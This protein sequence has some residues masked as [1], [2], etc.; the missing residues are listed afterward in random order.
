M[1][2][3][4]WS[5]GQEGRDTAIMQHTLEQTVEPQSHQLADWGRSWAEY[6]V[7]AECCSPAYVKAP[8]HQFRLDMLIN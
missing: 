6:G 1:H 4:H 5:A 8:A 3:L 7:A 2:L